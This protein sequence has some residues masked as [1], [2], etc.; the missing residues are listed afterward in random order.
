MDSVS[1]LPCQIDCF[2]RSIDTKVLSCEQEATGKENEGRF[3]VLLETSVL[4]PES[5]GQP[6]D[7]GSI[8]V[9]DGNSQVEVLDVQRC[10]DGRVA[11][12]TA[13]P[14]V[15]GA[16]VRVSVDWGRRYDHMQQ[17]T[18]QHLVSA[19]CDEV[20]GA[21]T[22]SWELHARGG[23]LGSSD[24]VM[25]DLATPSL[26]PEQMQAIEQR[27]NAV[28][29]EA[30]AVRQ[31][32]VNES[33]REALAASQL[34][35]GNLPPADRVK[36]AVRL[37]EIEGVDINACGGTHLQS[38]AELQV[39]KLTG[40]ER[41]R[42]M[43]RLCFV[44]GDRVISALSGFLTLEASLNKTERK[45]LAKKGRLLTDE[46]ATAAGRLVASN[47]SN[48]S[49]FH[50]H[51][52]DA[53]ASFLGLVA[54][55]ALKANPTALILL[56]GGAPLPA[57]KPA[58]AAAGFFVVAGPPDVVKRA[59]PRV[60]EALGAKGGGRPGLYQGKTDLLGNAAAAKAVLDE[61]AATAAGPHPS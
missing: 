15:Q 17:H 2:L 28:I 23:E 12:N 36:G 6:S 33:N 30:H 10:E 39:I 5:G 59:G 43:A 51:R 7:R 22:V 58:K 18:G 29:R 31:V 37:I 13:V 49:S 60:A 19:V 47:C 56:T 44:A 8:T 26:S 46:V 52:D 24:N 53:D 27:C 14:V 11:H 9:F 61:E 50:Y 57:G 38:T 48:G 21:D 4:Y 32:L 45:D 54:N 20:L 35:R 3:R 34:L 1:L 40:L 16:S 42:G 55:A 25:V 41:T